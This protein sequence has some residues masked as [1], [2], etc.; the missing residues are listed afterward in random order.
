MRINTI[1]LYYLYYSPYYN[2]IACRILH[3]LSSCNPHPQEHVCRIHK[4]T[5]TFTICYNSA[6]IP[7]SISYFHSSHL[8]PFIEI[9]CHLSYYIVIIILLNN[10]NTCNKYPLFKTPCPQGAGKMTSND[11]TSPMLLPLVAA[12][13][14]ELVTPQQFYYDFFWSFF[15]IILQVLVELLLDG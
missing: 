1:E 5:P 7:P 13:A 4:K 15:P 12:L 6:V 3:P 14:N 2:R 9:Y 8:S 11:D 10:I